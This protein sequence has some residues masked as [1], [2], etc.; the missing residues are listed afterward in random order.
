[1]YNF[2]NYLIYIVFIVSG[3]LIITP[4]LAAEQPIKSTSN[5]ATPSLQ[6]SHGGAKTQGFDIAS[7]L[8]GLQRQL[9]QVRDSVPK[10]AEE[11]SKLNQEQF[12]KLQEEIQKQLN[13]LQDQI[14]QVQTATSMQN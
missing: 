11:Q 10:M 3:A 13:V 6:Q 2:R 7:A 4:L 12:I 5:K 9:K 1:M 8:N 14:Q